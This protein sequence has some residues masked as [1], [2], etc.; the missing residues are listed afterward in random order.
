MT[1]ENS[2]VFFLNGYS[3]HS[4]HGCLPMKTVGKCMIDERAGMCY[5]SVGNVT[6]IVSGT[7]PEERLVP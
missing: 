7:K 2:I 4:E 6:V 1:Y 5:P 3:Q